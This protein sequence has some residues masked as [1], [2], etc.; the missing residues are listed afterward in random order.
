LGQRSDFV[1]RFAE[2]FRVHVPAGISRELDVGVTQDALDD[3]NVQARALQERG[4]CVP[5]RVRTT[6]DLACSWLNKTALRN[7]LC[8]TGEFYGD[9][10]SQA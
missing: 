6:S 3:V 9:S 10:H 4:R 8:I 1:H 2:V 5:K 7:T